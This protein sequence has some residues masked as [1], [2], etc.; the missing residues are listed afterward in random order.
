MHLPFETLQ[1][2][3]DDLPAPPQDRG[4]VVLVVSRPDTGIRE[5]PE[6]CSLTLTGGV[7]GD[8]WSRKSGAKPDNQITIIRSDVARLVANGQAPELCGDNLHVDL[9]L[10]DQNL[11]AGTRVRIGTA[12]CEVTPLP[13][14][15]CSK[16]SARFGPDARAFTNAPENAH[17]RLRGLHVRVIEE[18]TVSPGDAI[19]VLSRPNA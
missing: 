9:D 6:R 1:Q 12:L 16:F 18:G 4:T 2:Q 3:F 8:R 13:H 15:G 11:P 14:T 17:L 5:L 19:E 10:S 7:H